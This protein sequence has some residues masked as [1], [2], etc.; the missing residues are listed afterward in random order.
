M[1]GSNFMKAG[2]CGWLN[3]NITGSYLSKA[4]K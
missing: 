3:Q 1:K 4:N 2:D